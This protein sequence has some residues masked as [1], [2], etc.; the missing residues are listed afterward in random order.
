MF[1][2][3]AQDGSV[4][5]IEASSPVP[6]DGP[7]AEEAEV[8]ELDAEDMVDH[9]RQML[10]HYVR[11]IDRQ[12]D[13]RREMARDED[14]YDNE[15]WSDEDKAI[16]EA[17][18]QKA[19]SYNVVATPIDWVL[20]SERRART[21]Y[22][23]LSR[24]KNDSKPAE[25]KGSILKYL[26]D[27][28]REPFHW[29][30]AFADAC[31]AGLGWI[32]D[33]IEDG[34]DEP[35]YTRRESWRNMLHD[36]SATEKD[37]SDA[38]YIFRTKWVD[39]DIAVAMFKDREDVI[40]QAI[41]STDQ[42]VDLSYFGDEPM[43]IREIE[44][45]RVNVSRRAD[46]SVGG[47]WRKRVR[48]IEV[49]HRRPVETEV[50][51]GGQFG[52]ELHDKES[53][54]HL[55]E[56][57]AGDAMIRKR[58]TM[59]MCVGIMTTSGWLYYGESPYRHNQFPFSPVWCYRRGRNGLPYGM[60]RRMRDIQEDVNKR[61]SKALHI[62]STNKTIMEKGA[63]DDIDEYREEAA[64]P[65]AVIVKNANK[66]LEM[67]AERELGQW[68]L[69]LMS[70]SIAL[71]QSSSGVTDELMGRST[72]AHSG[73]AIQ[74]RQDQGQMATSGIF[75]N[76][77]LARQLSG[78]KK[79]SLM[80]QF[81]GERKQ[82]RITNARG[83]AEYIEVNDGLPE[84]DIARSKADF[85]ISETDWRASVRQA[86]ADEL[87]NLMGKIAPVAPQAIIMM[88]DLLVESMDLPN[89]EELVKRIRQATGM[90]DPDQ[91]EPTPEEQARAQAMQQEKMLQIEMAMAQ[92]RK[93]IADSGLKEA[94]AQ[95]TLAQIPGEKVAAQ[96]RA[97]DASMKA[98]A[99]PAATH[100]ADHM[101]SESGFRSRSDEEADAAAPQM[102][103][104]LGLQQ[105]P[106]QGVDNVQVQ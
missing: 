4:R 57:A 19:I 35:I 59:R 73:I 79:L 63:V 16:L 53:R 46:D 62:L 15:Q 18:G 1:D 44:L 42:F 89:R 33:G 60:I 22:K 88:L 55:A 11:E 72:N 98:L 14:F 64:R 93:L 41:D 94:Q 52:G 75:D 2:L 24:R 84:N 96:D 45:D 12:Q 51:V 82:F 65:D 27:C 30:E 99:Q 8:H 70:R 74:S 5:R 29:S 100:V 48:L 58:M 80:E 47:Y 66:F 31:K 76:L 20:G 13:N 91:E 49:W 78:E 37:L 105:T 10:N 56:L 97:L 34:D 95:K 43:D 25:R 23:V 71:L 92:L 101:L 77:R 3:A 83:N 103:P 68:H 106:M 81:M 54:G 86:Q 21:D 38:R 69:E 26:S 36:S 7:G 87:F 85:V 28:N 104:R 61:A 6:E 40:N 90:R 50:Q 9:H 39:L 32:E 102:P 67:D 17:R